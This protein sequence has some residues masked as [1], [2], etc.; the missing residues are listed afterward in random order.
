MLPINHLAVAGVGREV[1]LFLDPPH[2]VATDKDTSKA[3]QGDG[4]Q[5][6]GN[7]VSWEW[8]GK[9][10][11]QQGRHARFLTPETSTTVPTDPERYVSFD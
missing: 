11:R 5:S 1:H 8:R 4:G 6:G 3:G 9:T 2:D 7:Q 10:S